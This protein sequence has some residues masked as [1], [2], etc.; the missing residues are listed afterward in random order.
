MSLLHPDRL[1]PPEARTRDI[2]RLI[3]AGIRDLPIFSPHGH[4]DPAWFAQEMA[5]SDPASL[6][7]RPDHYVLRML[8][9]QGVRLEDLGVAPLD[10][11]PAETDMREVWRRFA[12]QYYL[13]RG[14][15]TRLWMDHAFETLFG[16]EVPLGRE[17]ADAAYDRIAECLATPTFRPRALFERFGIEMLATTEGALDPLDHHRALRESGWAGN[18]V[19]TYRPD[20]V[21]D[22][23]H[24]LF[25]PGLDRLA[26]LT[27]CNLDRWDGYL[28]AHRARRFARPGRGDRPCGART[29]NR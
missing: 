7:V 29:A 21:T 12:A 19:T 24:P 13:F 2:A 9:S 10:G 5:F 15:P 1:F 25:R 26:D 18:V 3:Y 6:L 20:E 17:T 22:P 28:E 23:E 16:L 11:G 27:S 4:C 14:T 8:V